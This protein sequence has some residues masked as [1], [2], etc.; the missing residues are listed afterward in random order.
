MGTDLQEYTYHAWKRYNKIPQYE[1]N[2]KIVNFHDG[3]IVKSFYCDV[4]KAERACKME[5]KRSAPLKSRTK[6]STVY[7]D[8]AVG[9]HWLRNRKDGNDM[10]LIRKT[11]NKFNKRMV[12]KGCLSKSEQ[13]KLLGVSLAYEQILLPKMYESGG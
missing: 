12:A 13:E 3:N 4:I 7:F 11:A 1:N 9:A 6:A 2:I 10:E 8:L 5:S